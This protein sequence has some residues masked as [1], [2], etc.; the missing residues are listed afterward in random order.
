MLP[1]FTVNRKTGFLPRKDPLLE[2]PS[3]YDAI[4]KIL[5][6]AIMH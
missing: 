6:A 4:D 2:L 1:N 5:K 3:K